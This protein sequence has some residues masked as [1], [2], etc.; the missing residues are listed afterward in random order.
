MKAFLSGCEVTKGDLLF[1]EIEKSKLVWVK[2]EQY[3]IK[4]SESY[5]KLK[6]S[7]NLFIDGEYVIRC[8]SRIAE[9][10]Q[11]TFNEKCPIL[12]RNDSKFT[13][14]VVLKYHHDVVIVKYRQPYVICGTII[15]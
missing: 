7:L 13:S 10:N 2:Y 4:N 5:T 8:R 1:E 12:L 3:F 11:L 9:A 6:N 15:G 14:L